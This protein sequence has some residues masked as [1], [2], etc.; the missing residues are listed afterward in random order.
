MRHL[1]RP[2]RMHPVP[3]ALLVLGMLL[4]RPA[5]GDPPPFTP[6]N[7]ILVITD[8]QGYGDIG[9]TGN[10][11]IQTPAI[12]RLRTQ[13][14]LLN[15]FHVDPT[16]APTRAALM[17]GRYSDRVG[18]WHTIMGRNMLRTRE[19]T[20][21]DVFAESGYVTGLFGKWH[22]G[23]DYPYRPEDRGFR[24]S[25]HHKAGGVG[26]AP[27]YWGNDYFDDTYFVNGK[28]RQ[29]TGFC[30]DVWF[31]EGMKFIRQNRKQPF[32]AYISTNAPHGPFY[33]PLDYTEPYENNPGVST[34]EF[35]GMVTNLDDNLTAR[36][37]PGPRRPGR[38]HH[39]YF[40]DRQRHRR[41]P[42]GGPRLRRQHARQEGLA[43]RRRTPRALHH[44]LARRPD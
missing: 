24:H 38:Q 2:F 8:D 37:L 17:T 22:L 14:T 44:P 34:P 27:D 10:P 31:D 36:R 28:P 6:P 42:G 7:V 13:G 35:Y 41:R 11:V 16:C 43:V 12:D 3:F 4:A 33:C 23:D 9:F 25:V 20:M 30:T 40:H 18:V 39:S 19:V 15:N 26:Q 1:P 29:F 21:A 32:F 5:S